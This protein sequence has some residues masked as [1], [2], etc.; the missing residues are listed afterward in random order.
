MKTKM[1]LALHNSRSVA[2]TTSSNYYA[3]DSDIN[4]LRWC[5]VKWVVA[6][7]HCDVMVRLAG[8]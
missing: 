3:S 4:L 6:R 5:C 2:V 1:T 7:E 8:A